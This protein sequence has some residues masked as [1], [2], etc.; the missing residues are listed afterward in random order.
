MPPLPTPVLHAAAARLRPLPLEA[1]AWTVALVV[2]AVTDPLA[3][4][5]LDLCPFKAVG[6][7]EALGL[8]GC[9]GCGLGHSIAFLLHGDL[10]RSLEAHVLG[11]PALALLAGRI[12]HLGRTVFRAPVRRLPTA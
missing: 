8:G 7:F 5:L 1:T 9:P 10:A 3:P 2:L 12:V 11:G 4:P 6:L